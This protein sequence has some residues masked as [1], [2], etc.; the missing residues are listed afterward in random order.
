MERSHNPPRMGL[1]DDVQYRV[2]QHTNNLLLHTS[3]STEAVVLSG[4][5]P[6]TTSF[7]GRVNHIQIDASFT[8]SSRYNHGFSHLGSPQQVSR[9][10]FSA[11]QVPLL[12]SPDRT[13]QHGQV[14]PLVAAGV[15][16]GRIGSKCPAAKQ[17]TRPHLSPQSAAHQRGLPTT[18]N[19]QRLFKIVNVR[20]QPTDMTDG[21]LES[22][23]MIHSFDPRCE[24]EFQPVITPAWTPPYPHWLHS[25]SLDASYKVQSARL[26][27]S[28]DWINGC[29]TLM[30]LG[31]PPD[32]GVEHLPKKL[33]EVY[34]RYALKALP[35]IGIT[36]A[37]IVFGP[38]TRRVK[39][40]PG[41]VRPA[42]RGGSV[43]PLPGGNR[44]AAQPYGIKGASHPHGPGE[45]ELRPDT[46]PAGLNVMPS[47]PRYGV[48]DGIVAVAKCQPA[49]LPMDN[50]KRT[51]PEGS[52]YSESSRANDFVMSMV[53]L[54][55]D[56]T[57][58]A[59]EFWAVVSGGKCSLSGY[60][61]QAAC[62]PERIKM[63]GQAAAASVELHTLREALDRQGRPSHN[64][65]QSP[66]SSHGGRSAHP[67]PSRDGVSYRNT[68]DPGDS[69]KSK[70][71][72]E[73]QYR[74]GAV[75]PHIY[76][77]YHAPIER[78]LND[79]KMEFRRQ[80]VD[81]S[82]STLRLLFDN[83]AARDSLCLDVRSYC[84][85]VVT[86]KGPLGDEEM[87]KYQP[88][89]ST[90]LK[91][92]AG[93]MVDANGAICVTAMRPKTGDLQTKKLTIR[94]GL[95]LLP[96]IVK[97]VPVVVYDLPSQEEIVAKAAAMAA[98][99]TPSPER[100]SG[101]LSPST[102]QQ[103]AVS[104]TGEKIKSPSHQLFQ[105]QQ[106][107]AGSTAVLPTPRATGTP[108]PTASP[109]GGIV[110]NPAAS[111]PAR[112]S[113]LPVAPT[114]RL[115][116]QLPHSHQTAP[117][118]QPLV[119]KGVHAGGIPG[120]TTVVGLFDD[121]DDDEPTVPSKPSPLM[122]KSSGATPT[123]TPTLLGT[124]KPTAS[125]TATTPKAS[126]SQ[127]ALTKRQRSGSPIG[128]GISQ[129]ADSAGAKRIRPSASP[130]R[131][132][133]VG[134]V[135]ADTEA[136]NER[137]TP[138]PKQKAKP[139]GKGEVSSATVGGNVK[140]VR[141]NLKSS[142][143][144]PQPQPTSYPQVRATH[145]TT[146]MS[147]DTDSGSS[148]GSS[149]S[150]S[151]SSDDESDDDSTP[152][153]AENKK[154][155]DLSEPREV[156][157]KEKELKRKEKE[158]LSKEKEAVSE[159]RKVMSKE[160]RV[161]SREKEV[162]SRE[163]DVVSKANELVTKEVMGHEKEL[164]NKDKEV[165]SNKRPTSHHQEVISNKRSA[166]QS[167]GIAEVKKVKTT[168]GAS[169][170]APAS[171][172]A[173]P[174][175]SMSAMPSSASLIPPPPV[176]GVT[177]TY[178]VT[179]SPDGQAEI[180]SAASTSSSSPSIK[181]RLNALEMQKRRRREQQS[182]PTLSPHTSIA[183]R[184]APD[185][186]SSASQL[187]NM[188]CI[189]VVAAS[190]AVGTM[191]ASDADAAFTLSVAIDGPSI[192]QL[193]TQDCILPQR[194]K[195]AT[196]PGENNAGDVRRSNRVRSDHRLRSS[197]AVFDDPTDEEEVLNPTAKKKAS[198]ARAKIKG[199]VK[200]KAKAEEDV[201]SPATKRRVN[202][203]SVL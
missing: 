31:V 110:S 111:V 35:T 180:S 71:S 8:Q 60:K 52:R 86:S 46:R 162:V 108:T 112:S 11:L 22:P 73:R 113:T 15:K 92:P 118:P 192:P 55:F 72:E 167:E 188:A 63:F 53:H 7:A 45:S 105:Q 128:T 49:A 78:L 6:I 69:P 109:T 174:T 61:L 102:C 198:K 157:S 142:G 93:N 153:A 138:I 146:N 169:S 154:S 145:S 17:Q 122:N 91:P 137:N 16:Y 190:N 41:D 165:R 56:T 30:I 65:T 66:Y 107:H 150:V 44:A 83:P 103:P 163:K 43:R 68:S 203:S 168:A 97:L 58:H 158:V 79:K 14:L 164:V 123:Q 36:S 48:S 34:N 200:P 179:V 172:C 94:A 57:D 47:G 131:R 140:Q 26:S 114:A 183:L 147:S 159:E 134:S 115:S 106:Q 196:A 117:Q 37:T 155:K 54:D 121:D 191:S 24:K 143:P 148:T 187:P 77:G 87:E 149:S 76:R 10:A 197:S 126:P 182:S 39:A 195:D 160:N 1:A 173:S 133:S 135:S 96:E 62:D 178:G 132:E 29:H 124:H 127:T 104:P 129:A 130:I 170:S 181:P 74:Y 33:T 202:R 101:L 28:R 40:K 38:R 100:L 4:R 70:T 95:F 194:E 116:P 139:I 186:P 98:A 119:M 125:D 42:V 75:I 90:A 84:Y 144:T 9:S 59:R 185:A 5:R 193:L 80:T 81:G 99:N 151:S 23:K 3:S 27:E 120:S 51:C 25:L 13:S 184:N 32:I 19:Y 141:D 201:M 156:V 136:I 18:F 64:F 50:M 21:A 166:P 189:D 88:F 82:P 89:F 85:G 2:H 199:K 176:I 161:V 20:A 171:R 175:A 177:L 152:A 67:T 12:P